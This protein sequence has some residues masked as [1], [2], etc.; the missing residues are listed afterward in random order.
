MQTMA[1]VVDMDPCQLKAA[2]VPAGD[3]PPLNH[4]DVEK[5]APRQ[6]PGNPG[7]GWSRPKDNYF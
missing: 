6:L 1:S 2:G 4:A 7:A 3:R 5:P